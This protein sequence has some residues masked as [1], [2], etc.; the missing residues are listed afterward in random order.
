MARRRA[1]QRPFHRDA[2]L[3]AC[4]LA[5][6]ER[7]GR[8]GGARVVRVGLAAT[9]PLPA[10]P[11]VAFGLAGALVPGL[12]PGTLVTARR[13]VDADGRTLW[14]GEPVAVPAARAFVLCS[15]GRVVDRPA[16]RQA[17]AARSGAEVADMES[18]RLAAS[19]RLVGVVKAIS[20]SPARP[21]GRLAGAATPDGEVDWRVV[22][23]AVAAEPRVALGA[24]VAARRGLASLERAAASLAALRETRPPRSTPRS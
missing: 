24:A 16:D 17:L 22:A 14:E 4:A 3:L 9:L 5:S 8:A 12:E 23:R 18:G 2:P 1:A 11:F 10:E 15:A 7:A 13:I 20:D 19:A 21:L 6:E